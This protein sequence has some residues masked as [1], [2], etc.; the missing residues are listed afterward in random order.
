MSEISKRIHVIAIG[1]AIMHNLAIAL[2]NR[3]HSVTGSD[4]AIYDPAKAN[5]EKAGLYP[6]VIG[7]DADRITADIDFIIVGM[8][9]RANN[10]ELLRA[11][12]LGLSILS[13]PEFIALEAK[14][15]KR[16]VVAGSHGKTTTTAM[17]MHVLSKLNR[18]FD[19]VV[20]SSIEGFELSVK[21]SEAPLIVIE[22]DEYLT[23]PL[24]LRSKFLWY[25]PHVSIITGIAYDHINVF[26]TWESYVDTFKEFIET[27][28]NN[29]KY[30]WYAGDETLRG[31][32]QG[33]DVTNEP[34]DTPNYISDKSGT[35][36]T[37]GGVQYTLNI[38]GKHNLENLRAAE[39]VCKE[40]GISEEEFYNAA[41]DFSGAGRRME[42]I[43]ENSKQVVYRDFAHSPSK[44]KA[45]T[46]AIKETYEG[47]LLAVFELHTFSSLTKDFLPLY[48]DSMTPAD[49]AVVFFSEGVFEHKKMPVLSAEYVAE[50]FGDVTIITNKEELEA[51]VRK[52]YVAG[53]NVLLM[54]SGTFSGATLSWD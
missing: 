23:S 33:T 34:Y 20:G 16:I 15:K 50:C 48:E 24:D 28:L 3:K 11:Q 51:L 27:H 9:A 8:H 49:Q 35:Q 30:F 31:L 22:G 12:E 6:Q 53:S 40:I 13:F 38:V 46:A 7:W 10:P 45:T 25:K 2:S 4:D 29:T 54:S 43:V 42:K 19:Y 5:L 37:V 36:L 47:D 18:D 32:S 44:L 21:L 14:E 39:L 1:G 17:I 41:A 26:P 52:R